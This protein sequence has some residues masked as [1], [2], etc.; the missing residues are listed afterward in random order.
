MV[1]RSVIVLAG[2]AAILVLAV[3]SE[4]RDE[5]GSDGSAPRAATPAATTVATARLAGACHGAKPPARYDHVVWIWFENHGLDA[6]IGSPK[7]PYINAVTRTCGLA[8]RYS[9]ISHPSLPNYI[10]ATSGG[11]QGIHNDDPPQAN[12]T[13]AVSIFQIVRSWRSYQESMA[14]P[15]ALKSSHRYAVRHDPAAY[16]LR[17]RST[18]CARDVPLG[19]PTSGALASDLRRNRLPKFS[20]ITPDVCNDMHDC[21][22]GTGDAWLRRWLPVLL[23]SRAYRA[24]KTAIFITWDESEGGKGNRVATIAVAPSVRRGSRTNVALDHYSLLRT[25]ESMLNVRPLLGSAA[26]ARSMRGPLHL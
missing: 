19:T 15:C 5:M 20:F 21:S 8:T 23:S 25:T 17:I 14:R 11:T 2:L 24:G 1:R 12:A 16:Y 26:H 10:A 9:A 4:A 7:A 13:R 3:A 22:V 6:V 18:L